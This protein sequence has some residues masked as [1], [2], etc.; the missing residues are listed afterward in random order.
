MPP[1]LLNPNTEGGG[2]GE[3]SVIESKLGEG[4]LPTGFD[5]YKLWFRFRLKFKFNLRI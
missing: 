4:R 2:T 3:E 1:P 5:L